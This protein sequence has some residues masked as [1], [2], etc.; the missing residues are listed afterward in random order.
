MQDLIDATAED[1]LELLPL[2]AGQGWTVRGSGE[3]RNG[4]DECPLCALAVKVLG[5][6][7]YRYARETPRVS[8]GIDDVLTPIGMA[9]I[10]V[11]ADIKRAILRPRLMAALGMT[12]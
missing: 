2:V 5:N 1:W 10:I 9:D 11:A 3:I 12:P 8:W 7:L 4:A 6:G